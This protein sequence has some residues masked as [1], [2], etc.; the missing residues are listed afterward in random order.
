MSDAIFGYPNIYAEIASICM[1]SD[2]DRVDEMLIAGV[3]KEVYKLF[4][5]T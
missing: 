1:Q 5:I 2:G 3:G 4:A